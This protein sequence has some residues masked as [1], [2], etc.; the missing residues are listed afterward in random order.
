VRGLRLPD[1]RLVLLSD[2]VGF[3]RKLPHQLV[4]AFRATLE[5][6]VHAD[7]LLHVVDASSEYYLEHI[8]AV[9][10]VLQELGCSEK[11]MVH[12]FNKSDLLDTPAAERL[13]HQVE[14]F[15]DSVLV[16]ATR[17]LGLQELLVFIEGRLPDHRVRLR[18][19]VPYAEQQLRSSLYEMGHVLSEK[20]ES[21]WVI[22]EVLVEPFLAEKIQPFLV[23][24]I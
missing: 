14:R 11:A 20:F 10:V 6:V 1:G 2:T 13:K 16:S 7:L 12:V 23:E 8:E 21:D 22:L 17:S 18:V 24:S 3:L 15:S 19:K 9:Q 5:E 4:A